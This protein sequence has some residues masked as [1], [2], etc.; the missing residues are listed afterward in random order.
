MLYSSNTFAVADPRILIY[1]HNY[2]LLPKRW[3]QMRCLSIRYTSGGWDHSRLRSWELIAHLPQLAGLTV[4][5][6]RSSDESFQT[7]IEWLRPMLQIKGVRKFKIAIL[8]LEHV[9]GSAGSGWRDTVVEHLREGGVEVVEAAAAASP[10][11]ICTLPM[12]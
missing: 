7:D 6:W 1:F 5:V 2:S 11:D 9:G 3:R 12:H 4:T 10:V 8:R